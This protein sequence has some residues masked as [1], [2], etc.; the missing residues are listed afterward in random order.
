MRE[1]V[2][3]LADE[4]DFLELQKDHAGNILVGQ[5]QIVVV[6]AVAPGSDVETLYYEAIGVT[7]PTPSSDPSP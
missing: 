4:G 2:Q 1:V 3:K 6:G 5:D 7:P